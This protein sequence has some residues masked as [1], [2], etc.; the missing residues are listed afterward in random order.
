MMDLGII[1]RNRQCLARRIDRIFIVIEQGNQQK[2]MG[3]C[4]FRRVSHGQAGFLNCSLQLVLLEQQRPKFQVSCAI[5]RRKLSRMLGLFQSFAGLSHVV[6]GS[7]Q[8]YSGCGIRRIGS[9]R[10][11]SFR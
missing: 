11:F 4:V 10:L 6:Q 1:G 7:G 8:G 2:Q 3:M 9:Y 5:Q